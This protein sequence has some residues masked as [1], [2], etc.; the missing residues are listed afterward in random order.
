MK[1]SPVS[2]DGVSVESPIVLWIVTAVGA[3]F[4]TGF[5]WFDGMKLGRFVCEDIDRFGEAM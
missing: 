4:G 3:V 2:D 5:V 1:N